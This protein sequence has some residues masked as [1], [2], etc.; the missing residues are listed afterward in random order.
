MKNRV[1]FFLLITLFIGFAASFFTQLVYAQKPQAKP[2]ETNAGDGK[3]A[4]TLISEKYQKLGNW[5]ADFSQEIFSIGLGKGRFSMGQFVFKSPDQFRFTITS[6][7]VS[8]FVSNGKEAWFIQNRKFKGKT[9]QLVRH[10]KNVSNVELSKYLIFLR[11][12]KDALKDYTVTGS[13]N[14]DLVQLELSPK[15]NSEISKIALMFNQ[16]AEAPSKIIIEDSLQTKTILTLNK[17][18][19]ISN[20]DANK[21]SF[22]PKITEG[23]KIEEM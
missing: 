1:I 22:E 4:L 3:V 15:T 7:D 20:D 18:Q 23:A 21:L 2:P 16:F 10:F 11:G 6:P 8:E 13:I 17:Y 5:K 9:T 14:D 19:K 12:Q